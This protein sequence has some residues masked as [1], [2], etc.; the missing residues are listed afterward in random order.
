[1]PTSAPPSAI[2]MYRIGVGATSTSRRIPTHAGK[3]RAPTEPPRRSDRRRRG[4]PAPARAGRRA[5]GPRAPV[6]A[7]EDRRGE[8]RSVHGT[9]STDR[10]RR[11]RDAGRHLH[12]REERVEAAELRPHRH[13]EHGLKRLRRDDARRGGRHRPRLR[14]TPG[15][16][17]STS[18]TKASSAS[19][20][21]WAERTRTSCSISSSAQR[22]DGV[23]HRLPVGA[24]AH[25]DRDE[26]ASDTSRAYFAR[27]FFMS[28]ALR[29][30]RAVL[31]TSASS[32]S[33]SAMPS[34]I[35]IVSRCGGAVL[36]ADDREPP[37]GRVR[38]ARRELVQERPEG[39]DVARVVARERLERD[40]RGAARG[41]AL[42]LEPAA[43]QL[44][45]LAEPELRDRAIGLGA[46]A[47]VGVARRRPRSR[48]PTATA[49]ARE[50][51]RRPPG[52][53]RPPRQPPRPASRERRERARRRDRRSARTDGRGV[54]CASARGCAPTS[55]RRASRRTSP[56]PAAAGSRRRR[57]RAPRSTR[58]SS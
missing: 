23:L 18:A 49:A 22:L 9:R 51:A 15:A 39:V 25:D 1:M 21:R 19:G 26:G 11:D 3:R 42:V 41:R 24:R 13:A 6:R 54:P 17:A 45:L 57:G 8:Q 20:V 5:A 16:R 31:R 52:R 36:Q 58:R 14:R 4:R 33:E 2:R 34:R 50:R 56:A 28:A 35:W 29:P 37:N 53:G 40:Q 30:T 55:R 38:V 10:E 12:G 47:V 7:R 32:S 48:R 43:Q 44:E 27:D 46:D